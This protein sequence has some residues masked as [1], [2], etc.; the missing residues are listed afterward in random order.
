KMISESSSFI[1][2][3][4][5]EGAFC[6]LVTLLRHIKVGHGTKEH[7][8]EHHHIQAPNKEDVLNYEGERVELSKSIHHWAAVV[9]TWSKHCDK[10]EFY[11]LENVKVFNSVAINSNDMW[12]MMRKAYKI[13]YERYKD[14]FSW[15]FLAYPT[16]F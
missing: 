15:F 6:M 13:M 16:T 5:L 14:E 4:V 8:H 3:V 10:A 12:T 2:G 7:H 1:K 11:S 9:P